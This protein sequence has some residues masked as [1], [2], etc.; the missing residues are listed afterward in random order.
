MILSGVRGRQFPRILQ[1]IPLTADNASNVGSWT[2]SGLTAY[3]GK[4][5]LLVHTKSNAGSSPTF[6]GMTWD[7]AAFTI[8]GQAGINGL[9]MPIAAQAY[10]A[11]GNVGTGL[12]LVVTMSSANARDLTGYLIEFG[13]LA[14]TPFGAMPTPSVSNVAAASYGAALTM[15]DAEGLAIGLIS[16]YDASLPTDA[17][18]SGWAVLHRQRTAN[19]TTNDIYSVLAAKRPGATGSVTMTAATVGGSSVPNWAAS[20][21]EVMP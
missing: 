14:A 12:S 21:A 17:A 8:A 16:S 13:T 3:T 6:S 20:L 5:L 15:T 1:V 7:G 19:G 10:L 9:G 4:F 2:F 11:A 18:A